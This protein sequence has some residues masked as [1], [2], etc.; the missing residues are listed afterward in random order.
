MKKYHA[1]ELTDEDFPED[2][3]KP[4]KKRKAKKVPKLKPTITPFRGILICESE[5]EELKQQQYKQYRM[6]KFVL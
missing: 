6:K 1:N 2:K 4:I 3:G 5:P